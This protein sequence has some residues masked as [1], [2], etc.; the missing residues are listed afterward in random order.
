VAVSSW[1]ASTFITT[2]S[3]SRCWQRWR[4]WAGRIRFGE[5]I[6]RRRAALLPDLKEVYWA[7]DGR[8]S[9]DIATHRTLRTGR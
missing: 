3:V 4:Q 1:A 8:E 9:V 7:A 5:H 2:T 6:N